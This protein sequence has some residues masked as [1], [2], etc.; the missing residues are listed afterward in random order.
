[1]YRLYYKVFFRKKRN[2]IKYLILY[3]ILFLIFATTLIS[4]SYIKL[5]IDDELNIPQNTKISIIAQENQEF[6]TI[7]KLLENSKYISFIIYN[8]FCTIENDFQVMNFYDIHE[9][10]YFNDELVIYYNGNKLPNFHINNIKTIEINETTDNFGYSNNIMSKYLIEN[11]YCENWS[12]DIYLNTYYDIDKMLKYL[13]DNNI[14]SFYTSENMD[15]INAY[16]KL[17]N[18]TSYFIIFELFIFTLIIVY[19]VVQII[20][21]NKKDIIL[22]KSL[23]YFNLKIYF[24]FLFQIVI[25]I[26]LAFSI[27]SIIGAICLCLIFN[28]FITSLLFKLSF[29]IVPLFIILLISV[30]IILIY[31]WKIRKLNVKDL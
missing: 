5:C 23:G 15:E 20:Y 3:F 19:V 24:L 13:T 27:F 16:T 31:F 26:L 9:M 4:K 22:L 1:M 14:Q 11:N 6:Q 25:T 2:Y 18:L 7:N 17:Y 29:F 10:N 28:K 30:I 8:S 12:I 21:D